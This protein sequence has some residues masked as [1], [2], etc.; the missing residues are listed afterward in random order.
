[1]QAFSEPPLIWLSALYLLP[2]ALLIL[3][4]PTPSA[5][6]PVT[7]PR[8]AQ[9]SRSLGLGLFI[10]LGWNSAQTE[11]HKPLLFTRQVC[12]WKECC[13][14]KPKKQYSVSPSSWPNASGKPSNEDKGC[15]WLQSASILWHPVSEFSSAIYPPWI[16]ATLCSSMNWS[17]PLLKPF[18]PVAITTT[19]SSE[20]RTLITVWSTYL[21]PVQLLLIFIGQPWVLVLWWWG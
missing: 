8:L 3:S 1:M 20:F 15:H 13:C 6:D 16:I 4:E 2:L 21:F 12:W 19:H 14:I 10:C 11:G 5:P 7:P 17:D 9:D 18:K